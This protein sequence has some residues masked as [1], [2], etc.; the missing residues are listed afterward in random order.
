MTT[1]QQT[2]QSL[3]DQ[4]NALQDARQIDSIAFAII[5]PDG[6]PIFGH[7]NPTYDLLGALEQAKLAMGAKMLRDAEDAPG[8][9]SDTQDH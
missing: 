2:I 8:F 9:E 6:T 7:G 1:R 3:I 5:R 4:L